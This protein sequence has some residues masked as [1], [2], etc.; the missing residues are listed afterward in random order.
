M[1]WEIINKNGE[2]RQV[3]LSVSLAR[4]AQG[5]PTGFRGI[6][7]DVTARLKAEEAI[8][9]QAFHDSLTNLAN[10]ILFNDRLSMAM[11]RAKRAQKMVAV[12]VL[13]LDDFKDVN[14][15]WGHAAGDML[16]KEAA[17]RLA[18]QVRDTDTVARQG[19]DEFSIALSS[20]NSAEEARQIAEKIVASFYRP[21]QLDSVNAYV[22][23]SLGVSVYPDDGDDVEILIQ[24]AD[25]AMYDA[26]KQGRN[27]YAFFKKSS[28]AQAIPPLSSMKQ[29]SMKSST[30]KKAISG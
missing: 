23:A 28:A 15:R 25:Q 21:F 26:K 10:R 20:L 1:E 9:R 11:K 7:S 6:M 3:E 27:R 22:T 29:N 16:L 12:M 17:D 8:R 24:K 4:N 13:D 14:D 5:R 2:A 18:D 30:R 19:G